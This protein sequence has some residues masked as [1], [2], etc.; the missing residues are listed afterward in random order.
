MGY[1]CRCPEEEETPSKPSTSSLSG[2]Y[3]VTL[4]SLDPSGPRY[5]SSRFHLPASIP[6][7]NNPDPR[8][9]TS[10]CRYSSSETSTSSPSII[11]IDHIPRHGQRHSHLFLILLGISIHSTLVYSYRCFVFCLQF[12]YQLSSPQSFISIL[13][14]SNS[15][16]SARGSPN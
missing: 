8:I 3:Q 16:D 11:L 1:T 12:E 4:L 15:P 6:V 10:H 7:V 13:F 9:L 2:F 5:A 14:L